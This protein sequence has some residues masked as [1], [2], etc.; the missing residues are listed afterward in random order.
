MAIVP[1]NKKILS[2]LEQTLGGKIADL[3]IKVFGGESESVKGY[4]Y[5][6]PLFLDFT[7]DGEPQKL[8]LET[9][10]EGEF[11]HEGFADR[12][13]IML[14]KYPASKTLPKHARCLDSGAFLSSGDL[15]SL[16]RAEEFFVLTEFKIGEGY[17]HDLD[18]LAQAAQPEKLD[19]DRAKALALYLA[20]IHKTKKTAPNLYKRRIRELV[21]H[22]ECLM[23]LV[24]SYP[25]D[26]TLPGN[27][28]LE[29]IEIKA[30]QWRWRLRGKEDRLCQVH[31]DFHPW[32]L[33]FKEGSADFTA[34]DRSRGE[35]GEAADDLTALSINYVFF[36][37]QHH[38]KLTAAYE[39]LFRTFW[40]TYLEKTGDQEVLKVVQP[41]FAWR[42]L[43]VA[44]PVWYPNLAPQV[45]AAVFQFIGA[46]LAADKFDPAKVNGYLA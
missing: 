13:Q 38:G 36:S 18:R 17:F 29:D 41:F 24:D 22:G 39:P 3:K 43:V 2:Y 30:V 11:G 31:G 14:W 33:L 7:R 27:L 32:N 20:E 23:G 15:V 44:S 46:L 21:G 19:L 28:T 10:P 6:R 8:V 37:L 5:G 4:G 12:A 26:F 25:G 40:D 9:M 34:I 35:W 42:G 16:G 45:R 1:D